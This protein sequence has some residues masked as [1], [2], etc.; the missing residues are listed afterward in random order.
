M[1]RILNVQMLGEFTISWEDV[2]VKESDSRSRKVWLFLAYLIY[3][4]HRMVPK[5]E[6]VQL[7]DAEGRNS[8]SVRMLRNMRWN[9]RR[10]LGPL[11]DALGLE[12]IVTKGADCQWNP[13]VETRLDVDR[14]EQCLQKAEET[15]DA[16]ER[17]SLLLQALD[18][19]G[20]DFLEPLSSEPWVS[21]FMPYLQNQYLDLVLEVIPV[22]QER[23]EA[24]RIAELCRAAIRLSP[25]HETLHRELMCS[26]I[27]VE[28][29]EGANK[30]YENLRRLLSELGVMPD[31]ETRAVHREALLHI[32]TDSVSS[33]EIRERLREQALP[34]GALICDYATF[35]LFYQVEARSADRRGDAIHIGVLSVAGKNGKRLTARSIRKA[36]AQL[37]EQIQACLRIGD[38]ATCCSASQYIL[39]LVQANYENSHMVC[40]RVAR[41]FAKA[42]PRSGAEIRTSVFPLEPLS[43]A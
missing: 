17:K 3:H 12:L 2:T 24:L 39:L 32:E 25:Y 7:L 8:D 10:V 43:Q 6:L 37:G 21:Q 23:G 36:M 38:I 4:R 18:Q 15:D 11:S 29:Y 26:L 42:H 19:Y 27:A 41:A 14:F 5:D 28:D 35:R 22:L 1:E 33:D 9:A 34:T 30:A 31:D 13:E 16:K 40:N 20:G